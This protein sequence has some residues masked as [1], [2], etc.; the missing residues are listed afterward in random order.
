MER[1]VH[2]YLHTYNVQLLGE[3]VQREQ[4]EAQP[5]GPEYDDGPGY[6]LFGHVRC[7]QGRLTSFHIMLI[8]QCRA[9][10]AAH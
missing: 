4:C 1:S 9:Y 7:I 6:G 8:A 3:T 2:T 10:N 5:T